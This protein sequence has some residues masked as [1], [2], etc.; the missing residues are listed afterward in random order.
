MKHTTNSKG[1]PRKSFR[2]ALAF[3]VISLFSWTLLSD[4][5]LVSR[6]AQAAGFMVTNT[7]D[8]GA[9]SLRQAIIDSNS[10]GNFVDTITFN[11]PGGSLK[12]IHLATALPPIF[13]P[14]TIDGYTQPGASPNTL[15]VGDNAVLQIELDGTNL[16]TNAVVLQISGTDCTIKGLAINRASGQNVSAIRINHSNTRIEGNFIGINPAGTTALGNQFGI[17]V[18]T[19]ATSTT[20]GGLSP[21]ARNVISG[22]TNAGILILNDQNKNVKVQGNYIG[23]DASGTKDLGNGRGI[24]VLDCSGVTIGGVTAGSRNVISGNDVHGITLSG[25]ETNT[26]IQGNYIGTQADGVSALGNLPNGIYIDGVRDNTVGGTG[27]GAGNMIA[28]NTVHGVSVEG[29]TATGNAILSN[30]TF[31]NFQ[32]GIYLQGNFANDSGDGDIGPNNRQ[33]HPVI[34]A[35]LTNGGLNTTVHATLNSNPNGVFRIEVFANDSCPGNLGEGKTF[36]G[37][38]SLTTDG[39]GNGAVDF[40]LA[41]F[42]PAGTAL[43]A[44]ATSAGNDTS[45]FSPCAIVAVP[46]SISVSDLSKSEG[47]SGTTN[48]DFNVTLSA[49][50]IQTVTVDYTSMPGTATAG[51]DYL[52][53]AEKLTFAAGETSKTA[54]VMVKGDPD[55]EPNETFTLQ[56]SNPVNATLQKPQ[57]TGTII[58]D[59]APAQPTFEFSQPNLMVQED[60]STVTLTVIRTGDTSGPASVD[61][62]TQDNKATQKTDYEIAAGTL[63]FAPGETSKTLTILINEDAY[64]EGDELF[65]VALS[66]PAGASLGQTNTSSVTIVDDLPES[67][68]SPID[69]APAF[70]C[71]QYHDFLNRAPDPDGLA[72]WTKEITSCGNDT[73][74]IEAKRVNVSAAFFLS[75]E[76]QQTGYL[77]YL[78]QKE[79]FGSTPKYAEFMRD[80]QEVSRGVVVTAPGWE[81]KLKDNQQQFAEKWTARPAFKALYDALSNDAYVN[82]IYKN[83]GIV[84]PQAQKDKL[85]A[86]LNAGS[87]NRAAVLLDVAADATFRQQEQNAAFVM[88]E[89]FGYL[90][91]DPN[92]APDSDL[93]G[94]NFWLNKLNQFGGNYL[95]AEMIKAFITSFEY[96]QRF[97]Q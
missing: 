4:S 76:F 64:I 92:A 57:G 96:R 48:F 90:R 24:Q 67:A 83:A 46:P 82:A 72:F 19:N 42:V 17:L 26:T 30:S 80:A 53:T 45:F 86:A 49:A 22:N 60:L 21:A 5:S 50:S 56:L 36:V 18:S 31:G 6:R 79:S 63:N 3:A 70:V 11:I 40:G 23:T 69:N 8:A 41:T 87:K 95:D 1:L 15:A 38:T 20:I 77:R 71:M 25:T 47:N 61:Y 34:S 93:S 62:T 58:N 28:Y 91:R 75:I 66:N 54:T 73:Q 35:M 7:N 84:P 88:M 52:P 27:A 14:V 16:P 74:C 44:T 81:Q 59:D 68:S 9:G 55:D 10:N 32:A 39:A 85:V 51:S 89:Y 65:K 37:A 97:A 12:T 33:N 43:T 2:L 94:Y 13:F 78:L 29:D